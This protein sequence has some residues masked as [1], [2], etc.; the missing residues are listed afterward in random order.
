MDSGFV[1]REIKERG[2]LRS[3]GEIAGRIRFLE[4]VKEE[5]LRRK[6]VKNADIVRVKVALKELYWVLG[7]KEK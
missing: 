6:N 4:G 2:S 7:V 1:R 3:I 5:Y